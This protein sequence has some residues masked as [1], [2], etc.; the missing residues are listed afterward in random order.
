MW[1][2]CPRRW[3][4]RLSGRKSV[5]AT[6]SKDFSRAG[7]ARDFFYETRLA[8]APSRCCKREDSFGGESIERD[9]S[10]QSC[11]F[12]QNGIFGKRQFLP[13][14]DWRFAP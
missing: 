14:F 9:L 5:T 13:G 7:S 12:S 6:I 3:A 10:A 2:N 1:T 11:A 4:A 8:I